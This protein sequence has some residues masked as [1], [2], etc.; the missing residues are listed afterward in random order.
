MQELHV[1]VCVRVTEPDRHRVLLKFGRGTGLL[2]LQRLVAGGADSCGGAP[3]KAD[4]AH[5]T[6]SLLRLCLLV[7]SHSEHTCGP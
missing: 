3:L 4:S 7:A 6:L 2:I 1:A 5:I